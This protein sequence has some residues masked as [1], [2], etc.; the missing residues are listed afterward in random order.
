M[1]RFSDAVVNELTKRNKY[2]IPV[3][4]IYSRKTQDIASIAAPRD[5]IARFANVC[6]DWTNSTGTYRYEPKVVSFPEVRTY[7]DGRINTAE[8]TFSNVARGEGSMARFV[9]DNHVKGCWMVIRLV[10]PDH[11]EESHVLFW[12]KC[13]RPGEITGKTLT[14]TASQELGN[15]K[16]EIPFREYQINCPLEFARPG[17]GCLGNQTLAEKSIAYRQAV[18]TYGTSGC[19]KR[20]STCTLLNNTNYFQGQ[21]V[22]SVSGQFS[23]VTIEEVVKRVLFWTKRKKVR[24][25]KTDSWSSVNQS[26]S[27]ETIPFAFGRCQIQGHPF[28]WADIGQQV[29]ALQGFCEGKISAFSF[30][31]SRTE[32]INTLQIIEHLGD[33]GG[34][35]TQQ[36]DTMF[37]G[38]SGFNSRLAYLEVLT[39]GSS[40]TQVDDAPLITAVIR[41]LEVPVPDVNG[42]YTITD[43]T[44]N[45]VH[46]LRF[47]FNDIRIGR[48]PLY[49]IDD[50]VNLETAADCDSIVEDRTNDEA[51]VLPSNEYDN[52]GQG[53]RRYRSASRITAYRDLYERDEL[54]N[55]LLAAEAPQFEEPEVKWFNPFEQYV[56]PEPYSVLRQKY[57]FNGAL[58]EKTQLLD[59]VYERILPTF[60]GF[61]NYNSKGKIEIRNKRP[62]D[63]GYL[64]MDTKFTDSRIPVSN[65]KPWV[66]DLSGYVIIG[67]SLETAEV[68][69]TTGFQYSTAC[70]GLPIASTV[71][72]TVTATTSGTMSGGNLSSPALGYI[73]IGG[74]VTAGSKVEIDFNSGD[75]LFTVEYRADGIEDLPCFARMLTAFLN[76]NM[77]F[78]SYLTAYILPSDPTRIW[79]RCEAGYLRLDKGLQYPHSQFEEVLR[80]R[81]V[82]ENCGELT[83]NESGRFDNIIDDSFSFNANSGEEINAI[84]A[85]YTSAID[86]FHLTNILPRAAWDTIDLEGEINKEEMDLTFVDNY[87]Q[88]AFLA[89]SKAIEVIDGNVAFQWRT[90][91]SAAHLELYDVVAIRH[92]S[93]DGVLNYIPVWLDDVSYNLEDFT[94]DMHGMLYLSAAHS[95]HVQP[96]DVLLTTTLNVNDIPEVIPPTIGTSGGT[97]GGSEPNVPAPE[98]RYYAQFNTAKYSP[99]GVDIV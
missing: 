3:V 24:V 82:F 86:D 26:E 45:P 91:I 76:A 50:E 63:N 98:H 14:I 42:E 28:T 25:V 48:I 41:G 32:G 73:D 12:G 57:T 80:V 85:K 23:Y 43:W 70:N 49:R 29:R 6:F 95:L 55:S 77:Q 59:F 66:T 8:V 64:R 44:N 36:L 83:A 52:Y 58:Q 2:I 60:K 20:F 87:W 27:S 33:W 62:A 99:T 84:A 72:G 51:I 9:L 78:H 15:Y 74:T 79:I 18:A 31:R 10:F 19:N 40:P 90:S 67:V 37:N 1:I 38:S 4:E 92:D 75:D 46:I 47:L 56:L 81:H 11:P 34:V 39:D 89:K 16:Q 93:G 71:T 65:I 35:G 21:R 97:G 13:G 61:I 68:R 7:L 69:E 54:P 96:V 88:A 30:V 53:Y 17:G 94:M 22:V 5:A